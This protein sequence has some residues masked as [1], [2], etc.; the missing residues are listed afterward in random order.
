MLSLR[1]PGCSFLLKYFNGPFSGG[2][3]VGL[4]SA[5]RGRTPKGSLIVSGMMGFR[6]FS[7]CLEVVLVDSE[8]EGAPLY[9]EVALVGLRFGKEMRPPGTLSR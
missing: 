2:V 9:T 4:D 5:D 7:G 3:P 8:P 1:R 6:R